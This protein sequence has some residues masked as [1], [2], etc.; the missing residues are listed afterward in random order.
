MSPED[1]ESTCKRCGEVPIHCNCEQEE[2]FNWL[3]QRNKELESKLSAQEKEIENLNLTIQGMHTTLAAT[4]DEKERL[5]EVVESYKSME[6]NVIELLS[7]VTEPHKADAL[8]ELRCNYRDLANLEK[9]TIK[10]KSIHP[11]NDG[12]DAAN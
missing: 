5:R 1:K 7:A 3:E 9:G 4:R 11:L 10:P 8:F 6:F 12:V 2:Y